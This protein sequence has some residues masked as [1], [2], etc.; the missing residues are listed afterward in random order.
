LGIYYNSSTADIF[1]K[2][3]MTIAT[4]SLVMGFLGV[5]LRWVNAESYIM[6]YLSDASYWVYLVHV[7]LVYM[8]QAWLGDT[9]LPGVLKPVLCFI[10]P[11]AISLLTYQWFVRYT[12]I[13]FY[14]HGKREKMHPE[15][16]KTVYKMS[17]SKS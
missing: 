16:H 10:I 4:S 5:F 12:I 14:L 1:L 17:T 11:V 13:G 7:G 2:M 3:G 15:A 8:M 9:N 6:R